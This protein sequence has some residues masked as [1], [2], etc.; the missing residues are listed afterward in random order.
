MP[1]STEL[2]VMQQDSNSL[3][4]LEKAMLEKYGPMVGGATL[5]KV[6]GYPSA[7]ALR[8]ALSRGLIS[9]PVFEIQNRRGRFA[10]TQDVVAWL[11]QCRSTALSPL[12][13][14]SQVGESKKAAMHQ[15]R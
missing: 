10:L 8:Q 7:A 14:P 3:Q 5:C 12:A 11:S 6:L 4:S 9:V 2:G 15:F 13:T 1:N